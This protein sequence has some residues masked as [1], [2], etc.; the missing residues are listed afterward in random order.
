MKY[1]DLQENLGRVWFKPTKRSDQTSGAGAAIL[2][3][4]HRLGSIKEDS[5]YSSQILALY[6][7]A[8]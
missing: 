1:Y 3:P 6:P 8:G 7:F 5:K 2:P 4:A